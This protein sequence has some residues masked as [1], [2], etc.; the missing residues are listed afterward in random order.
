MIEMILVM[1]KQG[2]L[3][4][5][6]NKLTLSLSWDAAGLWDCLPHE[7]GKPIQAEGSSGQVA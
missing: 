7:P 1:T 3:P 4:V 5:L 2:T 6:P